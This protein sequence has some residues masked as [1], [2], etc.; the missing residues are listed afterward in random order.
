MTPTRAIARALDG[1]EGRSTPQPGMAEWLDV[2]TRARLASYLPELGIHGEAAIVY[3][4]KRWRWYLG[5]GALPSWPRAL[6]SEKEWIDRRA[7]EVLDD[8]RDGLPA[9]AEERKPRGAR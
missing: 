6:Q 8:H 1:V 9:L 5:K 2:P 4:V 3:A 7:W